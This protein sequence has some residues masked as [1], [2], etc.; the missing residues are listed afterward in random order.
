MGRE[1]AAAAVAVIA[2]KGGNIRS[3]GGYLRGMTER[4]REGRLNLH[5]SLW[6]LAEKRYDA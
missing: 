3:P 4:D 1:R 6:G 2:A 5:R